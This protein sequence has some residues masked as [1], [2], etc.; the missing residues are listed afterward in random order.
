MT[1]SGCTIP[2]GS[3]KSSRH[4]SNKANGKRKDLPPFSKIDHGNRSDPCLFLSSM[5]LDP[6]NPCRNDGGGSERLRQGEVN[7][8]TSAVV[9]KRYKI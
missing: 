1:I 5:A 6:G 7:D 8:Y 9:N 3:V 4:V 2:E